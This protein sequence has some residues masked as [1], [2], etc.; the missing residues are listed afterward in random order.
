VKHSATSTKKGNDK[1]R[2]GYDF[3]TLIELLV[4]IAIIAILA[5]MLLPA[6]SKARAR[7]QTISCR[8]NLKQLGLGWITYA[9][10]HNDTCMTAEFLA[11]EPV[12]HNGIKNLPAKIWCGYMSASPDFGGGKIGWPYKAG[13]GNNNFKGFINPSLCCPADADNPGIA[14]GM[15][16]AT[17]YAYNYWI[18]ISPAPEHTESNVT[19]QSLANNMSVIGK[20]ASETVVLMDDWRTRT[21]RTS[22]S[23]LA[24]SIFSVAVTYQINMGSYAA[25]QGGANVLFV[26]GHAEIRNSIKRTSAR[27][28]NINHTD[29]ALCIWNGRVISTMTY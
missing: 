26:D 20:Y 25:H 5:S 3:F 4:V 27:P 14:T 10:D 8:N 29:Y 7:A 28:V 12:F 2:K 21:T 13:I 23:R 18:N 22:S 11:P 1:M 9:G 17:S 15:A 19:A 16:M 24:H 6:L